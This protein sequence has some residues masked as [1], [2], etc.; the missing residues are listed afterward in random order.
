LKVL[1]YLLV[2]VTAF[3][4]VVMLNPFP[5][6]AQGPGQELTTRSK[7]AK[8][9]Y[10]QAIQYL[11]AKNYA[12]ALKE[13]LSA[14]DADGRFIEAYL[15]MGDVYAE[16]K[17]T[18][19]AIDSYKTAL[20]IDSVFFVNAY[21]LIG[22]LEL[23][24]GNYQNAQT[25]IH[26]Y[27]NK[28]NVL[29]EKRLLCESKL[30][31]CKFSLDAIDHPVPFNPK[32]LG[33]S[34]NSPAD[35]YINAITA[36]DSQL[37][38]TRKLMKPQQGSG[39]LRPEE[40]FYRS[41]QQG[42]AWSG[43]QPLG[44]PVNTPGDEGA[45]CISPDGM[46]LYFAAG[47][48]QDGL[49]R[50]DLYHAHRAG[51]RWTMPEN[52]G[53]PVNTESWES[54]PSISSDGKTLYFSSLR[55]GGQGSSDLWKSVKQEDGQWSEPVNLGKKINTSQSEMNPFI[56]P[57]GRTLYFSSS[58]HLGM[59]GY[60]LFYSRLDTTGQWSE[61][62]NLGYPINSYSDEL[63]LVVNARGNL[64][65]FS[66]DKLGGAGKEDIYSFELYPEAR[67]ELVT[68]LRGRVYDSKSRRPLEARFELI[69]LM[70]GKTVVNSFSEKSLG[71]FLVTLPA[72]RDYALHVSRKDYLFYSENFT[73]SGVHSSDKPFHK[74]IPL[75]PI[76]TG[77]IVVLNNIFFET[78][79]SE[80]LPRS[81][82]E[83]DKLLSL[84]IHNPHLKIEIRGHT[85]NVGSEDY[86]LKL[87]DSRAKVVN[88]YLLAKGIDRDRITYKGYGELL[89]VAGNDTE[90]GR[91]LNRRT[92]FKVV[93]K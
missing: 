84:L 79:R 91:G 68:Y 75:Q 85:D 66:S 22:N 2:R 47:Y 67:P 52:I 9:S 92:E 38:F 48:R 86:N 63:I 8:R 42:G 72:G 58:G 46:D 23:S 12:S 17:M 88:D 78:D 89:P 39:R 50:F 30:R 13:L 27:I 6:G 16:E 44:P 90:E 29:P 37:F 76:E 56:H 83:L 81:M 43:S 71:E 87:S 65:Y 15:M 82:V 21:F 69:D 59:G 74:D 57:D 51:E 4:L 33:D 28:I 60:D 11:S 73:L 20:E 53:Q 55:K 18:R 64:A 49:G 93:E 45:L 26:K 19:K 62:V 61:P 36:D 34:I 35:E 54:Q 25:Y 32:N 7:K 77:E 40:D 5:S 3:L 24:A 14:V 70:T 31:T 41:I 1:R 10:E 80:L